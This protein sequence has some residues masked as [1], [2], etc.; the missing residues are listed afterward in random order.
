ME[1]DEEFMSEATLRHCVVRFYSDKADSDGLYKQLGRALFEDNKALIVC[2]GNVRGSTTHEHCHIQ[3]Y[4]R[5]SDNQFKVKARELLKPVTPPQM[6]RPLSHKQG[7]VTE[8]GFQYMCKE[9]PPRILYQNHIDD[10]EIEALSD[11]SK[12]LLAT[13][14]AGLGQAL[15]E[16]HLDPGMGPAACYNEYYYHGYKYYEAQDKLPPQN[17]KHMLKGL[18]YKLDNCNKAWI[19]AVGQ[20]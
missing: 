6:P 9:Y 12:L 4:S 20:L 16:L 13:R 7:D 1:I 17:F 2:E 18:L 11:A 15:Q 8:L 19:C 5:L 10:D 14:K 3:G